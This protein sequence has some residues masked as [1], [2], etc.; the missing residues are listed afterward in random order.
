MGKEGQRKVAFTAKD[1]GHFRVLREFRECLGRVVDAHE[2]HPSFS[3]S[4]RLLEIGDYLSLLLFGLLNPVA[5]TL[6]GLN[7]ASKIKKVQKDVCTRPVSLGSLSEV[8]HLVDLEILE[9]VFE[10]LS[11]QLCDAQERDLTKKARNVEQWLAHDSSV[12]SALPRMSWAL[13]GGGRNGSAKAVSLNLSFHVGADAPTRALITEAQK[14]ERAA[15]REILKPG[16]AYVGDRYYGIDYGFFGELEQLGCKYCIRL[17][18]T[19]ELEVIEELEVSGPEAAAGVLRQGTVRLGLGNKSK[20]S[21]E[22]RV[23]H[24]RGV[25]GEILVLATNLTRG[26]LSGDEVALLYKKRWSIEYFFRWVKCVMRCD[27]WMAESLN[28]V[29]IQIYLALIASLLLQIQ[30]GRRPSKRVW[31]LLGWHQAGVL[32]DGELEALLADQLLAEQ[33]RR[34]KKPREPFWKNL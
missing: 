19:A 20:Q 29:S 18:D 31:E 4:K 16:S 28:G 15:L 1:L 30:L 23:V 8:Q 12:W 11:S 27:H 3:D 22:L 26:E 33:R 7:Q 17:R 13:Y 10:E 2:L 24:V 34:D 9:K 25:T 6:R 21:C 5:G 32:E 14:C